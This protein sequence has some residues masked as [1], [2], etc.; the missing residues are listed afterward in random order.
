MPQVVSRLWIGCA[1]NAIA[2]FIATSTSAQLIPDATLPVNSQVTQGCTV[3]TIDGGTVRGVN[4]FHSFREFSIPIGGSAWFNNTPQIQN[5][6]TRVTGNNL[7]N[8]DGLIRANGTANLFL[9]NP[10]GIVFGQNARLQIGG[11]FFAS[12]ANSFKFSDG[13]EFSATNPQAPPLLAVN[14]PLGL[15]SG[16]ISSGTIANRGNLSAGQDLI[17]EATHLDLQG[18]LI[19][20]RD[21]T[22]KA[23]DTVQIRDTATT[24]FLAQSGRDLMIQ[25]DRAIDILALS[26]PGQVPFQS[27]GNL[28]LLSDGIISG[29]AR[30][31]TGGSFQV[32]SVSGGAAQFR[33][34]YDPIISA[35][36][37]VEIIGDYNGVALLVESL[38]SV[39]FNGAVTIN[40]NDITFNPADPDPDLAALGGSN[41]FIVRAGRPALAYAPTGLPLINGGATFQA[42]AGLPASI[43]IAGDVLTNGGPIILATPNGNINTQ[44][45]L[46]AQFPT[47]NAG[48]ISVSTGN[49]DITIGGPVIPFSLGAGN[50]GAV[51][52][53]SGNGNIRLGGTVLAF[54]LGG[55]GGGVNIRTQSGD[56]SVADELNTFSTAAGVAGAIALSTGNGSITTTKLTAFTV[57]PGNGGSIQIIAGDPLNSPISGNIT[58]GEINTFAVNGAGGA[59]TLASSNGNIEANKII[60]NSFGGGTGGTATLAT[61]NGNIFIAPDND[62]QTI[63]FGGNG[64]NISVSTTN[65]TIAT[66]KLFSYSGTGDGGLVQVRNSGGDINVNG[67]LSASQGAGR[68]GNVAIANQD[69]SITTTFVVAQSQSGQGGDIAITADRGSLNRTSNLSS[70]G[71]IAFSEQG[72]GGSIFLQAADNIDFNNLNTSGKLGSGNITAIAGGDVF[73]RIRNTGLPQPVSP[74]IATDTFGIGRGGDIR[75]DARSVRIQDG[76]Q[77]SASTHGD[78]DGGN[79]TIRATESIDV[80]GVLP[81]GVNPGVEQNPAGV[82]RIPR[83]GDV[84]S[85]LPTGT[86][87]DKV[88]SNDIFPTGIFTQTDNISTGNAG[89]IFIETP[90]LT[91]WDGAAIAAT[92]FGQGNGGTIRLNTGAT[93]LTNGASILSGVAAG[94]AGISGAIEIQTQTLALTGGLIQSKTL[95]RGNAGAIQITATNAVALSGANSAIRSG[96]GDVQTTSGAIGDGASLR[97]I[98][99]ILEIRDRAVLSAE[100]YTASKGGSIFVTVDQFNV[101]TGG[102]LR[103][104]TFNSG[105]AGNIF[106]NAATQ[107]T[108]ADSGT[109]LFANTVAGSTGNGGS[110]FVNTNA[111]SI[112]QDAGI[113]VDSLGTGQGGSIQMKAN[114]VTL[115]DRGFLTA[116]TASAQGGNINLDI[117]DILLLR[118]N[119][120]ISATAGTAQGSG[121]GGNITIKALFIVG[122]LGENSDIRANAFTGNG[123][124]IN[125]TAQGIFGL[126][127]QPKLTSFSDITASSQFGINGTV[128]LNL[129][130]IDPNR[131]L[132]TLPLNLIDPASRIALGCSAGR[133]STK[134][135][136][137]V[138]LGR[139]GLPTSPED[140]FGGSQVLVNLVETKEIPGRPIASREQIMNAG[141]GHLTFTHSVVE[142]QGVAI[143]PNGVVSL[144]AQAQTVVPHSHWETPVECLGST[145]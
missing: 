132:V 39:R 26:H 14:V 124:K 137:F 46:S 126:R 8:I 107:F 133:Q 105:Q 134:E 36:G 106:V 93:T 44:T 101:A 52:I 37:D 47:G 45:L 117:R 53:V 102:Q 27:G 112:R 72:Q 18:Q 50:A 43:T 24:P 41:A 5:I 91:V 58:V 9:L 56:I 99:P 115:S 17:L 64:G 111:A 33:S 80:S 22:L 60:A 70:N 120:L 79:I 69:G 128:I 121:D 98:A 10:N 108:L 130:N 104:T 61:T 81:P 83:G 3:C 21:L 142:A 55:N 42:A 141:T 75:I 113:A 92:T 59:V 68:G 12:T 4:L 100:T 30:F 138:A 90:Q 13:S 54:S 131:G 11:S 97:I 1:V 84:G 129:P 89:T 110:I 94:S 85:Y 74:I 118:R 63:G 28:S 71:V 136:R 20:G 109:G 88:N 40:G 95:G 29:D 34:L 35:V 19:A 73:S 48:S 15:Q 25:G 51:N 66:G 86:T 2:T 76:A 116:E 103:T 31:A 144:I 67:I 6:L 140:S 82:V 57:D 16:S 77:I 114:R 123:G 135:N 145:P 23:Q 32:R 96:S 38:G 49:G 78:G 139:G 62:I 65:G 125:I 87:K 7:S 127:F 143:A 119:S 122:V